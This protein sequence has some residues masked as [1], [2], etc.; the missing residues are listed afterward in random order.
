M[1][2]EVCL[3]KMWIF[4][5]FDG[6]TR[7]NDMWCIGLAGP[8][9]R[10][11]EVQQCGDCPP[12]CCNFALTVIKDGKRNFK[13]S[14]HFSLRKFGSCCFFK[15]RICFLVSRERAVRIHCFSLIFQAELG[16]RLIRSTFYVVR[17]LRLLEDMD[18]PWW[19]M[20]GKIYFNEV[21]T[22]YKNVFKIF[23]V[24][25]TCTF[26]VEPPK[27]FIPPT[28]IA[29]ISIHILGVLWKV[30]RVHSP[31]RHRP[32][33]CFTPLLF[34][35]MPCKEI[36]RSNTVANQ[37]LTYRFVFGGTVD[38]N[39][40]SSEMFRFQFSSYPRCTLH[41]DFG[42]LLESR[43]FCDLRWFLNKFLLPLL[44][45]D[46]KLFLRFSVGKDSVPIYAHI[47]IV[48]A[49]SVFLRNKI[50]Q[51]RELAHHMHD[52]EVPLTSSSSSFQAVKVRENV[53]GLKNLVLVL[54]LVF[55]LL[56][57]LV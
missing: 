37:F 29:T 42:R 15:T 53:L 51:A 17:L 52:V 33:V 55:F 49:R 34:S 10:W 12:I 45:T 26:L 2:A 35:E 16:R 30:C 18:I 6:H 21:Y 44:S 48:A 4:G 36:L 28:Y 32:V 50:K 3:G 57:N 14:K 22:I 40:R 56:W 46:D 47:A 25:G 5:G 41:D 8:V 43:Q 54:V 39:V 13:T 9:H 7:L 27:T 23:H 24:T 1:T 31:G 38:N 11:Q 20:I 19:R